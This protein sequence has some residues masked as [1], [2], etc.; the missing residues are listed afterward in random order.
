MKFFER[1]FVVA[2]ATLCALSAGAAQAQDMVEIS[3]RGRSYVGRALAWDGSDALLM[4]NDGRMTVIPA[5]EQSDF[6]PVNRE[7]EPISNQELRDKLQREFGSKYQV[8]V[9][10]NFVVVHPKGAHS[11]W[12]QPFQTLYSRFRA[13]FETRGLS[14]DEPEFPMVAIVLRTRGEFDKFL[15][16]Y[17]RYDENIL[18]YYSPRSNRVVTYDQS[19]DAGTGNHWI[20][21]AETIVHEAAHQTAFNVGIHSRIGIVPTWLSEGLATMFEADGVNNCMHYSN[22]SDRINYDQF[23]N[24]QAAYREDKV[25]QALPGMI[26]DD[27]IFRSDPIQGY[28]MAWGLT[29]YLVET[30]PRKFHEFLRTNAARD[31]YATY[32]S[33]DRAEE[34][35]KCFGDLDTLAA[36]M[37]QFFEELPRR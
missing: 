30:Q 32:N 37:K 16:L 34:F 27:Q 22:L 26:T 10:P 14:L 35:V 13:Y 18:G 3:Y 11:R 25:I 28:S 23:R 15:R 8:S 1:V 5:D 33:A 31:E 19:D 17:H 2:V 29:F 4:R 12:A 20:L 7:F 6:Q 21:N 24:L 36:R 9:T